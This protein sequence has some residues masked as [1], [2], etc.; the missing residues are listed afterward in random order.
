[1]PTQLLSLP[2]LSRTGE[3]LRSAPAPPPP[4]IL[5]LCCWQRCFSRFFPHSLLPGTVLHFL[6]YTFTEALPASSE[7]LSCVL[8]QGRCAAGWDRPEPAGTGHARH[9]AAPASPHRGPC[10]LPASAGALTPR[11]KTEGISWLIELIPCN[12]RQT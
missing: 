1:M 8:Q 12:R 9:E 11:T 2:L 4:L 10:S 3:R 6:K 7:G 5:W